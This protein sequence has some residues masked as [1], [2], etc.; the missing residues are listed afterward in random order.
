M[1]K[2]IDSEGVEHYHSS[3]TSKYNKELEIFEDFDKHGVKIT[4]KD[5]SQMTR[6][7]TSEGYCTSFSKTSL[8]SDTQKKDFLQSRADK[9]FKESGFEANKNQMIKNLKI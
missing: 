3:T 4:N 9:N 6:V 8:M 1:P 7:K 5:G 2:Y